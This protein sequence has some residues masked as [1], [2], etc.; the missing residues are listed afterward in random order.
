MF[1][2]VSQ[3]SLQIFYNFLHPVMS[4]PLFSSILFCCTCS[5]YLV[6]FRAPN[7]FELN[8]SKK[9]NNIIDHVLTSICVFPKS[10]SE[11]FQFDLCIYI[12]LDFFINHTN[13]GLIKI[14]FY[15]A[16]SN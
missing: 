15:V 3:T 9:V 13:T 14:T 12:I 7:H 10:K 2:K 16:Y 6:K 4:Y 11:I 5:K 1:S 8:F